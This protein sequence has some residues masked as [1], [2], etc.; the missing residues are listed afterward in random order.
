MRRGLVLVFLLACGKSGDPA[1]DSVGRAQVVDLRAEDPRVAFTAHLERKGVRWVKRVDL[2]RPA[3]KPILKADPPKG[4]SS[5]EAPALDAFLRTVAKSRR[6]PPPAASGAKE[7]TVAMTVIGPVGRAPV[8]LERK[9]GAT[10][11]V[12]GESLA[13]PAPIDAAYRA[14]VKE[15]GIDRLVEWQL[16]GPAY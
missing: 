14:M 9:G 6:G 16:S 2:Q 3:E 10:W 15:L 7:P 11:T 1:L 5:V 13:E 8:A 12:D 4:D